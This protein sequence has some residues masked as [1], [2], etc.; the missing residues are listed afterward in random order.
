MDGTSLWR[1]SKEIDGLPGEWT[2]PIFTHRAAVFHTAESQQVLFYDPIGNDGHVPLLMQLTSR[3]A[4]QHV[5]P[6]YLPALSL[7]MHAYR[8]IFATPNDG[9]AP[10]PSADDDRVGQHT[11]RLVGFE[12]QGETWL[13]AKLLGH[14]LGRWRLWKAER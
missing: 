12:D 1:W 5:R 3:L 2:Y 4:D 9:R 14:G 13:F 7:T 11:V 8:S 6:E 10:L